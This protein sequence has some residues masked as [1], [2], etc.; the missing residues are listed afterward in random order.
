M[1]VPLANFKFVYNQ[2]LSEALKE[3]GEG[4]TVYILVANDADSLASLKI[5]TVSELFLI[6]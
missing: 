2:I 1:L 3:D 5:L 4:C 6:L